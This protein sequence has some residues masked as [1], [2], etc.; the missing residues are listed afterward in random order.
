MSV[1]EDLERKRDSNGYF[2]DLRHVHKH[3]SLC[4]QRL[5]R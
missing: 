5:V 2:P 3:G 1:F 4:R